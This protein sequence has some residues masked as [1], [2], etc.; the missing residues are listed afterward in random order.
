MEYRLP[1]INDH[2]ILKEYVEEHYANAERSISASMGLT[3]TDYAGWVEK[4]SR[5]AENA[6]DEWGKY[7][8]Y[9]AFDGD[10]LIGLLNIRFSL[11][12]EL[13]NAYGDIGYGVRPGERRKGYATEM[14][15]YALSVCKEKGMTDVII[16]CYAGN[17][18]SNKTVLNNGGVLICSREEKIRLSEDWTITL[19]DHFYRIILR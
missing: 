10:R 5:S 8:L 15:R 12:D 19:Q 9:L 16:G 1:T 18:G 7:C 11:S 13:R 14:L 17:I 2:G 3:G 6:V 4:I